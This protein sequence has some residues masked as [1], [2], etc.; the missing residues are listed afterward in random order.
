MHAPRL[1]VLLLLV[2]SGC[3]R[4]NDGEEEEEAALL[5]GAAV[6]EGL[7][8]G[9]GS[10]ISPQEL[11]RAI[12]PAHRELC[13]LPL[14]T[15]YRHLDAGLASY[16]RTVELHRGGHDSTQALSTS[17]KGLGNALRAFPQCA[18][19]AVCSPAPSSHASPSPL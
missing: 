1:P 7:M 13:G 2:V 10:R 5:R 12:G 14:S 4:A 8:A 17:V 11:P 9:V 15:A 16:S 6:F 3:T 18:F 19:V